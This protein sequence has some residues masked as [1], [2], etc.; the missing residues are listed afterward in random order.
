MLEM[1]SSAGAISETSTSFGMKE[2]V[3]NCTSAALA[4]GVA[5]WLAPTAPVNHMSYIFVSGVE[6]AVRAKLAL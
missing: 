6:E 1:Y 4:G 2:P 5:V 3:C